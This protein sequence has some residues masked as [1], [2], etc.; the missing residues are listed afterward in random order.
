MITFA[1]EIVISR[2]VEVV[3]AIITD[4]PGWRRWQPGLLASRLLTP[5]PVGVGTQAVTVRANFGQRFQIRVEVTE[6]V[7]NQLFAF[8]SVSGPITVSIWMTLTP[9]AGGTRLHQRTE[10]QPHGF[11]RVAQPM[12]AYP[13][14]REMPDGLARLKVLLEHQPSGSPRATAMD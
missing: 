4:I 12:L 9:V 13:L 6:C 5:E 11:F 7:P 10:G 2:P 14:T 8:R 3:F 1:N